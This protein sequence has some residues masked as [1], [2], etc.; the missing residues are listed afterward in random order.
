M[1]YIYKEISLDDFTMSFCN[2][3]RRGQFSYEALCKLYDYLTRLAEDT[4]TP[5]ELDVIAL[6]CEFT[7]YE[8]IQAYNR[9]HDD[10][11]KS[12]GDVE[13]FAGI[14]KDKGAIVRNT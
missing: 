14:T 8:S 6:C 3:G 10:D 1:T 4:G 11:C 7:E 13:G 5:I 9:E 12:W 2:Y